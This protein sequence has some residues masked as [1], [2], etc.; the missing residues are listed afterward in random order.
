MKQILHSYFPGQIRKKTYRII[1]T[2][3][4]RGIAQTVK[5]GRCRPYPGPDRNDTQLKSLTGIHSEEIRLNG[6]ERIRY[7]FP[8]PAL[9]SAAGGAGLG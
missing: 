8:D 5:A 3:I 1:S 4:G 2:I 9:L 6:P 7:R